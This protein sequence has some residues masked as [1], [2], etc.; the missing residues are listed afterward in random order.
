MDCIAHFHCP[1][2]EGSEVP[3]V[4]QREYECGSHECGKNTSSGLGEFILADG[5]KVKA[6]YLDHHGPNI[7]FNSSVDP[8]LVTEFI[9]ANF[10]LAEKTGGY[11]I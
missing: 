8:A 4:S 10:D 11:Q 1:K 6:V 9:D 7:V 2:R 5:S 3:T